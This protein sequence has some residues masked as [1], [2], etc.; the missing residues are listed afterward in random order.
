MAELNPEKTSFNIEKKP[1]EINRLDRIYFDEKGSLEIEAVR[2]EFRKHNAKLI[3]I[4]AGD[5]LFSIFLE[6]DKDQ[7]E[8]LEEFVNYKK[9]GS[10]SEDKNPF[11]DC[12]ADFVKY[13]RKRYSVAG[14]RCS[15]SEFQKGINN[16]S[17]YGLDKRELESFFKVDLYDE[18]MLINREL[19]PALVAVTL[20]H[21]INHLGEDL[22]KMASFKFVKK[23]DKALGEEYSKHLRYIYEILTD[24]RTLSLVPEETLNLAK[25]GY[26]DNLNKE[27]LFYL[28]GLIYDSGAKNTKEVLEFLKDEIIRNNRLENIL[29]KEFP[30]KKDYV[31]EGIKKNFQTITKEI[32]GFDKYKSS[33]KQTG[34]V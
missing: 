28:R 17:E 6:N 26:F 2:N 16:L 15:K 24:I 25:F 31:W 21:E 10:V 7:K 27:D 20:M 34:V 3:Q 23:E 14:R 33:G 8:Y 4:K 19:K 22:N 11:Y 29:R 12:Y 18:F 30:N 32:L 5:L 9:Y 1:E 13:F